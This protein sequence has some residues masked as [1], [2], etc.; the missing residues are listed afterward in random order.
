MQFPPIFSQRT[1]KRVAIGMIILSVIFLIMMTFKIGGDAFIFTLGSF[2]NAPLAIGITIF[3]ATIWRLL[4]T[5]NQPR[6]LWAGL[7]LG[8]GL[9]ALAETIWL[10]ASLLGQEVPYPSLADLFW[11]AGYIPIGYGLIARLRLLTTKPSRRQNWFLWGISAATLVAT[12]VFVFKPIIEYFDPQRLIESLLNILYPLADL[13]LAILTWRLF[14]AFE[15]GDQGFS[16]RLLA[17]G[18]LLMTTSD[19]I[20]TYASW[21]EIYYPDMQANLISRLFIDTPYTLSYLAWFLGLFALRLLLGTPPAEETVVPPKRVA[22][23]GYILIAT[24][25][26]DTIIHTSSNSNALFGDESLAGKTLAQALSIPDSEGQAITGMLRN[27]GKVTDLPVHIRNQAGS[28]QEISL[29][30]L[31]VLDPQKEFLG[32]NLLLCIPV[33][34]DSINQSLSAESKSMVRY[35]LE[36]SRSRH[37][38]EIGR[39]LVEYH[40][41]YLQ[42]LSRMMFHQG[43]APMAQSL[44]EA[45]KETS[46]AHNWTISFNPETML[47]KYWESLEVLQE[48]LPILR[49][50]AEQF[51]ARPLNMETV[52]GRMKEIDAQ[53]EEAIHREVKRYLKP[54]GEV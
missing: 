49:E 26:D 38:A 6:R 8:W 21:G 54:G 27:N 28:L 46:K 29:C 43:G 12:G 19:F 14:F 40:L 44:L 7:V 51:V 23:L 22:P 31:A 45:L 1:Y 48:A 18:F 37:L 11:V 47:G 5:K 53:I 35:I 24:K 32:S 25:N 30:G 39:F 42:A 2:I 15:K 52:A 13:F 34:D 41:I 3:A 50:T 20:F 36:K 16:W 33:E 9:W 10:V 4:A 17:A